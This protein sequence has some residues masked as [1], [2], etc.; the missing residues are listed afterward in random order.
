MIK[1]E[2]IRNWQVLFGAGLILVAAAVLRIIP[3]KYG[4]SGNIFFDEQ[5]IIDA[6]L[7]IHGSFL[8]N[9]GCFDWPHAFIY[10]VALACQAVSIFGHEL[11]MENFYA[12]GR[13]ISAFFGTATPG[14]M[15]FW[16]W[17][18]GGI[19]TGLF[20]GILFAFLFTPVEYSHYARVDS[21]LTFWSTLTLILISL[22]SGATGF[23][24]TFFL[25]GAAAALGLAVA[26][27]YKG[28]L[29]A[30]PFFLIYIY[31]Q[32]KESAG[33]AVGP[34]P[35]IS[36]FLSTLVLAGI[37]LAGFLLKDQVFAWVLT[38]TTDGH[39][40]EY[41]LKL[42]GK[43]LKILATG[44]L[45][46]A[47][48][49]YSLWRTARGFLWKRVFC[50]ESLVLFALAGLVFFAAT[51]Y[52]FFDWP[53]ALK[54]FFFHYRKLKTGPMASFPEMEAI[55]MAAIPASTGFHSALFYVKA[56]SAEF[57]IF[58][59]ACAVIGGMI[60]WFR[61]RSLFLALVL[62]TTVV[63]LSFFS[64]VYVANRYILP[65]YPVLVLF[66]AL[67][68][69]ELLTWIGGQRVILRAPLFAISI[70]FSLAYTVLYTLIFF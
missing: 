67:G 14:L 32:K 13:L 33:L 38:L 55:S 34:A 10:A 17:K 35:L 21:A 18:M 25:R 57:G 29:L 8:A 20:A 64:G 37:A 40:E 41:Y 42:Y 48:L 49:A 11:S 28:V 4:L 7:K 36:L 61:R 15:I 53:S 31:G 68:L 39:I 62:Y 9:P 47:G 16:G 63:L 51:P 23:Q 70:F 54:N 44:S 3:L 2:K 56:L 27:E 58:N 1:G 59:L 65:A 46:T 5:L 6:A 69:N 52:V 45:I 24:R 19:R 43:A 30:V 22:G 60:V 66:A 26:T 12:A 50:G